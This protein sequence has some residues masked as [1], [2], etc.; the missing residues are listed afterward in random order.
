M[1]D[2]MGTVCSTGWEKRNS[3]RMLVGKP[4]GKRQLG[5]SRRKCE[6][7]I[8]IYLRGCGGMDWFVLAENRGQWRVLVN[9]V[10]NLRVV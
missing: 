8:K 1:E 9:T 7:N 4:E 3:Y 10:R 6:V 5:R 2:E